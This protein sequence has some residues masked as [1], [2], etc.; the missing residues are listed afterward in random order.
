MTLKTGDPETE[1]WTRRSVAGDPRLSEA[2]NL[3]RELGFEVLLLPAGDSAADKADGAC[4][5]CLAG[6]NNGE[7]VIYT[8]PAREFTGR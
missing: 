4:A 7:M 8:R 6:G 5:Q 3:Y 2:V 1:G